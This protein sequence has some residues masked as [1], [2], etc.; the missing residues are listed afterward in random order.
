MA[1]NNYS[2]RK[3]RISKGLMSGFTLEGDSRLTA[4]PSEGVHT[5]YLR[6]IDGVENDATWGRLWFDLELDEGMV[7]YLHVM[8]LNQT[9]FYRKSLVTNIEDF[10]TDP[11]EPREVKK[12][13]FKQ[14][15]GIRVINTEDVLLYELKG[16]YLYIA[17]EVY[18]D[19]KCIIDRMRVDTLGDQ[20]ITLFPEIYQEKNTFF[21][22]FLSVFSS[23]YNDF[24]EEIDDLPNL[25]DLDKC[26]G[27]LLPV[28]G[29]WLGVDTGS[30]L[31]EESVLRTLVKEAYSLCR[32]KGTAAAI[33][34]ISE[35]ILKDRVLVVEH[36]QMSLM[37]T[38]GKS[39]M[40]TD[41][42]S[43]TY[44]GENSL[45]RTGENSKNPRGAKDERKKSSLEISETDVYI[46]TKVRVDAV[47]R[48][49]LMY[50]LDQFRP[51]RT[52]LN[53]VIL[54]EDSML[55]SYSMLDFNAVIR[56]AAEGV[57]DADMESD[58]GIVLG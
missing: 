46:Y 21:H 38:V 14:A 58:M 42:K 57:L 47:L 26:P 43:L 12:E 33:K 44:N 23:I 45:V 32:I 53:L 19:G 13:L 29:R 3:N 50:I 20:F 11:L 5:L 6:A 24:G 36:D 49:S 54:R 56:G 41:D 27:F 37:H 31:F 51:V 4:T 40:Y 17:I 2:I 10:L 48:K 30:A 35:I 28:Y 15:G 9:S 22:R 7:C 55:D 52:R 1:G 18:G 39:P 16:R 8:A 34:R 25:L